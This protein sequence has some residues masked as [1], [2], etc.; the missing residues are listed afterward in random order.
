MNGDQ[1]LSQD[2]LLNYV[3]KNVQQHLQE[4]KDKN[5]QLFLLIDKNADG[6]SLP[7]IDNF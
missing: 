2:E 1:H 5:L 4:A 6:K 3:L 7:K